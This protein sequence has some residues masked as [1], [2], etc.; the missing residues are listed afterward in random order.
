MLVLEKILVASGKDEKIVDIMLI[1]DAICHCYTDIDEK[2]LLRAKD[3]ICSLY[4]RWNL[5]RV[6]IIPHNDMEGLER[7]A[8]EKDATLYTDDESIA[9]FWQKWM[10]DFEQNMVLIK[11]ADVS[12]QNALKQAFEKV[13]LH[14][15]F[16]TQAQEFRDAAKLIMQV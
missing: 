14:D 3:E 10:L 9:I 5:K 6:R 12:L 11:E 15:N 4:G 8:A 7:R 16:A 2:C 13:Y 1:D